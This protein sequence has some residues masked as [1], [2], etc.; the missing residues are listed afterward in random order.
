MRS[1]VSLSFILSILTVAFIFSSCDKDEEGKAK[2]FSIYSIPVSDTLP[3]LISENTAI[4]RGRNWYVR[5][6][7]Y[8][9]NEAT[10]RIDSGTVIRMLSQAKGHTEYPASGIVISRGAKILAKGSRQYPI[11]FLLADSALLK[12]EAWNGIMILGRAPSKYTTIS[13][14]YY[15]WFGYGMASGGDQPDDSSGV[16]EHVRIERNENHCPAGV[17]ALSSGLQLSNTGKRTLVKDVTITVKEASPKV[18]Y[19]RGN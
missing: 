19:N 15:P 3:A 11:H 13:T 1:S 14:N 8:V 18:R 5:G 6:I 16:L 4:T 10:L 17:S 2:P 7:V 9:V 12:G